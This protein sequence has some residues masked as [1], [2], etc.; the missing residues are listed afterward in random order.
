MSSDTEWLANLKVG[1]EVAVPFRTGNLGRPCKVARVTK[2]GIGV[3]SGDGIRW[4]RKSDGMSN[5]DAPF[6]VAL[7]PVT[8][9]DRRR[10]ALAA[11]SLVDPW[12]LESVPTDRIEQ[13]LALLT[14]EG[15]TP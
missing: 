15:S 4:F 2:T 5:D 7:R 3:P 9:A 8:E 6:D 12:N 14:P 10:A 11:L 1:D 13:A